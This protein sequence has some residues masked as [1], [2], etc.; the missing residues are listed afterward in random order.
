MKWSHVFLLVLGL[1]ASTAWYFSRP[2]P[3]GSENPIVALVA[4]NAPVLLWLMRGVDVFLEHDRDRA[5]FDLAP[6]GG[7]RMKTRSDRPR[8]PGAAT[9][10][11]SLLALMLIAP[12]ALAQDPI[13]E[14]RR[15]ADQGNADAQYQL[16]LMYDF[17]EGVP[18]DDATAVRWYRLAAEQGH[19]ETEFRLGSIYA[20][21]IG[22]PQDEAESGR[23]YRLAAEHG[24]SGAQA[25][26]G[27]WYYSGA[28]GVPKDD[29]EA[30]RWWRLAAEQGDFGA[31]HRLG[32]MYARGH[33]V[34]KDP[35]LAHMWHN[36]ASANGNEFARGSRDNMERDMTPDEITR[37]TELARECMASDYQ[38][39]G[40]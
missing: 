37:A 5:L 38:D 1:A 8:I 13:A 22:V 2:F 27:T 7:F 36:I 40:Q 24:H 25:S 18:E 4:L 16:G 9:L 3:D 29:S 35:V 39:C 11:A 6:Q 34:L 23:W 21:G 17:G 31:Q 14:L 12:W 30:V 26:L 33:G 32:L 19:A 15:Q 20:V 28:R 10:A